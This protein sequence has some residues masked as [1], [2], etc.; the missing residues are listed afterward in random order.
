MKTRDACFGK[1]I[2]SL[3]LVVSI[4][5]VYWQVGSHGFV[6][7]DDY[8][9]TGNAHLKRGLDFQ[10][11]AWAFTTFECANWHP[12]TWISHLLDVELFGFTPGGH[13]LMNVALHAANTLLLFLLFCR[14]TG[15]IARSGI[16]AAFFALHPLHVE[17]VAWVAERK[18]L[19]CAFFWMLSLHGYC[20]YAT[21]RRLAGY[22]LVLACFT[23]GLM[24]KPMIVTLPF[25]LLLLDYWPLHRLAAWRTGGIT[26]GQMLP[27]WRLL[28]EKLPL[29]ALAAASC[30]V[31]MAAQR[32]GKA[33][34]S[35]N[36][37]SF[38][39]RVANALVSYA[40]Y[41][42]K[43]LW[44]ADLAVFYPFRLEI[45][46]WQSAAAAALLACITFAALRYRQQKPYLL[47]G[48]LWYLGT[49]VPVIGLVQVGLQSMADRYSYIPLTGIFVMIIWGVGDAVAKWQR[50]SLL[51][52]TLAGAAL[53]GCGIVT[54][55]QVATWRSPKTLF[56]HALASTD[57][58]FLAYFNLG[59]AL[60]SEGLIDEA[61]ANYQKAFDIFPKLGMVNFKLGSILHKKGMLDEAIDHYYLELRYF[62]R[63]AACYNNLG[64]ALAEKGEYDEAMEIFTRALALEPDNSFTKSN[65]EKTLQLKR[66]AR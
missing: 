37:I 51:L 49:L 11:I 47:F 36:F 33:V 48:W 44:P 35:L 5:A 53:M 32:S 41:L 42:G 23:L 56:S 27:Y 13:H 43:M 50:R 65:L 55:N 57:N 4:S 1:I 21:R 66:S 17:S 14:L 61:F 46:L 31:T 2:I 45:P 9:I 38:P 30:A 26:D 29:F 64:I 6:Y 12:L 59:A 52:R 3:L 25:V 7:D 10:S 18:E 16:L 24:A 8:Y 60:E 19:L 39:E 15:A 28:L 34:T 58:N 40:S 20:C 54:W 62:P 22:L 63:F